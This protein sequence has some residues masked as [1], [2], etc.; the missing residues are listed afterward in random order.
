[1]TSPGRL[2]QMAK[3]WARELGSPRFK[4]HELLVAEVVQ[5][6]FRE[7]EERGRNPDAVLKEMLKRIDDGIGP[8]I[9][10]APA[11]D[12]AA[13]RQPDAGDDDGDGVN[14]EGTEPHGVGSGKRG[15]GKP[16]PA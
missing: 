8:V 2:L 12:L 1:M 6:G 4:N 16:D 9:D 11:I 14:P 13:A 3:E 15:P 10:L 5:W 7:V